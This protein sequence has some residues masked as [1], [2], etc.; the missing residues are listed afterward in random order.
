M[1]LEE[2]LAESFA[3]VSVQGLHGL[4]TGIT[5]PVRYG[6]VSLFTKY[7]LQDG[8]VMPVVPEILTR[9]E[10]HVLVQSFV[11]QWPA[12]RTRFATFGSMKIDWM[13][14]PQGRPRWIATVTPAKDIRCGVIVADDLAQVTEARMTALRTRS[15]LAQWPQ[16]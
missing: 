15:I 12:F 7:T 16:A 6:Y 4:L 10:V 11:S 5:F 14:E 8:A 9:D 1:Y 13:N 3:Q 2:A